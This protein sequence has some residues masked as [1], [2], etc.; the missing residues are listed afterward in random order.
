[1]MYVAYKKQNQNIDNEI[2]ISVFTLTKKYH[3]N[4]TKK[5]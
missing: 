3:N 4:F 5:E 1:M 2:F